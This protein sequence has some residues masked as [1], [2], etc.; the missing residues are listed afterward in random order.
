MTA[1]NWIFLG[2]CAAALLYAV[3]VVDKKAQQEFDARKEGLK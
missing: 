1:D 3:Y 2:I